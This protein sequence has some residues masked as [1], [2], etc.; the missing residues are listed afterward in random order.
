MSRAF[1][2]APEGAST[3]DPAQ[4]GSDPSRPSGPGACEA[5]C[6]PAGM[7]FPGLKRSIDAGDPRGFREFGRVLLGRKGVL[8]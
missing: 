6:R 4:V 5:G 8:E 1:S 2:P 7:G 3:R